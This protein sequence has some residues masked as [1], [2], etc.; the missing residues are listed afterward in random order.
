MKKAILLIFLSSVVTLIITLIVFEVKAQQDQL[1]ADKV[2]KIDSEI[3]SESRKL[4]VHLP[5]D[6]DS[7]LDKRY[8]V[9]FALD[10][11]SHDQDVL[12]AA[13][14][15]C[16]AELLTQMIIVGII[17]KDRKKDLTP[18]YIM[19]EDDPSKIG[20][21]MA[22]LEFLAKEAIPFFDQHLDLNRFLY[23]SLG[24]EENDKMKMGFEAMINLIEKKDSTGLNAHYFYT[25]NA[26]HGTNAYYSIP[27]A[28]RIWNEKI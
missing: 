9:L 14:V 16:S 2:E 7:N 15:L 23:L 20:D 25:Q 28:L 18:N 10:A 1:R 27:L 17:N 8:P 4:L 21:G 5:K 3:L 26:D 12:N 13:N 24:T 11:T 22:F 19:K 6:Y